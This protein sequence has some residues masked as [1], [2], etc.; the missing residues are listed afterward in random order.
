[1]VRQ[2]FERTVY[3]VRAS[4]YGYGLNHDRELVLYLRDPAGNRTMVSVIPDPD[5]PEV[6]ATSRAPLFRA[7]RQWVADHA[8]PPT[9]KIDRPLE[10]IIVGVAMYNR[11]NDQTG[12][13]ENGIEI[14]PVLSI[15]EVP[16][17]PV[18][19]APLAIPAGGPTPSHPA[20]ASAIR[21]HR[22]TIVRRVSIRRGRGNRRRRGWRRRRRRTVVVVRRMRGGM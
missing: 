17:A 22:R 7:A 2:W 6:A 4:L 14:H 12:M 11:L 20:P 16:P 3:R 21:K 9:E 19:G 13:S 18:A 1:M 8:G 10:V 5:C 15:E